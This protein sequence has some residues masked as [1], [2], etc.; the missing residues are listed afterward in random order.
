MHIF[1]FY[2]L[3]DIAFWCL[4]SFL[5]ML[6]SYGALRAWGLQGGWSLQ[7]RVVVNGLRW[8]DLI[9]VGLLMVFFM[10]EFFGQPAAEKRAMGELPE[11]IV[12][13]L[14]GTIFIVLAL[15]MFATL[16]GRVNYRELFGLDASWV[17]ICVVV[18]LALIL[19]FGLFNGLSAL[20]YEDWMTQRIGVQEEQ[21]P[22]KMMR[23]GGSEAQ[24]LAMVVAAC[25]LAPVGEELL[26]RG[27]I[28]PVLKKHSDIY[29]SAVL[30]GVFFGLVHG[31]LWSLVP[32]SILG[33]ILAFV[34]EWSG[35][36]WASILL[37]AA[38]NTLTALAI[39]S[40]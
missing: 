32:L 28:Y 26:F 13:L 33:V 6:P 1:E 22:V 21:L 31:H 12:F 19:V 30:S 10:L 23:A 29:F 40:E 36:L 18:S 4:L 39:Y 20:G 15:M 11:A 5:V 27:Y 17:R 8:F 7:G 37:H 24:K 35:S 25:V 16:V 14:P 34:Y 2:I 38:F 9:G 3:Q